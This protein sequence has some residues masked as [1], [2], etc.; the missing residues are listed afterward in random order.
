MPVLGL[1]ALGY[2]LAES[3]E[4]PLRSAAFLTM[5][6]ACVIVSCTLWLG[7]WRRQIKAESVEIN[8]KLGDV[9]MTLTDV[10]DE[11]KAVNHAV[12]HVEP[13]DP[14]PLI[15]R[16]RDLE[17]AAIDHRAHDLWHRQVLAILAKNMGVE[18]PPHP[19]DYAA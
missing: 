16:V 5:A 8:T 3:L 19:K 7:V 1:A 12:N 14:A 4:G 18:L 10:H 9:K 17:V 11:V 6:A 13:T 2:V 15:Q